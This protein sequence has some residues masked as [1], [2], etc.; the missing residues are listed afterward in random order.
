MI[1][2]ARPGHSVG[3]KAIN[4][5]SSLFVSRS[6]LA[7]VLSV[8][9]SQGVLAMCRQGSRVH[10]RR[11]LAAGASA[12]EDAC[13]GRANA[14]GCVAELVLHLGAPRPPNPVQRTCVHR[15]RPIRPPP[16][17]E[18]KLRHRPR[19]RRPT[20]ISPK[21]HR[22]QQ[23]PIRRGR[24]QSTHVE[25]GRRWRLGGRLLVRWSVS[26]SVDGRPVPDWIP[27]RGLHPAVPGRSLGRPYRIR[28]LAA[29]AD[30]LGLV[31]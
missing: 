3:I 24:A 29:D 21:G 4:L 26:S 23:V 19:P 9:R 31:P 16:G 17:K 20:R 12:Q 1:Q 8:R 28:V 25:E 30:A 14:V 18:E 11:P 22:P 7:L 13:A 2:G 6:N 27:S 5:T 10:L 15:P